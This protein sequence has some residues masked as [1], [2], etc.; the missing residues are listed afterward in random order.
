MHKF[1]TLALLFSLALTATADD[2]AN[3][4]VICTEADHKSSYDSCMLI[5]TACETTVEG[6][7]SVGGSLEEACITAAT[8]V[9]QTSLDSVSFSDCECEIECSGS[10]MVVLSFLALFAK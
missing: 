5:Q 1:I 9:L 2:H 4:T 3:D 10:S 8:E 6:C 7:Q